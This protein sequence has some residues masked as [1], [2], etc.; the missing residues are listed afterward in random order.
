MTH[1]AHTTI[2]LKTHNKQ[3]CDGYQA[4]SH[5]WAK[6][7]IGNHISDNVTTNRL[8]RTEKTEHMVLFWLGFEV[9]VTGTEES[10]TQPKE[11]LY[12]SR[13][14]MIPPKMLTLND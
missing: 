8:R 2:T 3:L 1:P 12:I 11:A 4:S 6:L 14:K 9:K 7:S 10:H 13:S 5:L